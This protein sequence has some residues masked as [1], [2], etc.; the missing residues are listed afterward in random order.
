M[1]TLQE[2]HKSVA[3][4]VNTRQSKLPKPE[5][6]I[7]VNGKPKSGKVV[8]QTLVNVNAIKAAIQKLKEI[9]WLYKDC[10]D[11]CI[12]EVAKHVIETGNNST[13]PILVKASKEDAAGFQAYTIRSMNEKCSTMSDIEQYK[14]L[15][16]KDDAFDNRQKFLDVM[17]FPHL[18]PSGT[19]GQFHPCQ[20]KLTA[21]EYAK[22]RLLNKN[23]RFRKE[24]PYVF[25]LLWQQELRELSAGIYNLMKKNAK[26]AIPVNAFLDKVA[27]SDDTVE[28]NISTIFQS[29]RGSK[30]YWFLR[31]SELRC[32]VREFGP[33]TLFLTFSCAEYESADI[34]SYLRKVNNVPASYPIGKLCCEDPISVS[35]KFSLKFHAFFKTVILKGNVLGR[36][37]HYFYKK[38]YQARGAPHYHA[39][40][41]I[42]G[43]PVIGESPEG[44]VL[45]WLNER[46][47]CH[48]PEEESNP[49]LHR[50]VTRY[51]MHKCSR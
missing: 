24:A 38:E 49:E 20:M 32:M 4:H 27:H 21:S 1:E 46:I 18:F 44:V 35:R 3:S 28:A 14:L 26:Q 13:T 29:I 34:D 19:F 5:L 33:P 9:N 47:C 12:D 42:E 23:S 41:W 37:T 30:Q 36:V 50:L 25:Y 39:V 6:Y 40:V 31:S 43:A 48:I 51:Q 22:S 17:C 2:L 45:K 7:I 8:W 10:D 15:S 11:N 16:V